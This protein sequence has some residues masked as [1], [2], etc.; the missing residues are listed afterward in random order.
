MYSNYDQLIFEEYIGGQEIQVGVLNDFPLG[1]IEL[2][3]KRLFYDY[4]AK[5]TKSA[6]TH[7]LCQQI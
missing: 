1:A 3:P 2:K 6:K 4:K 5:Y 7:I